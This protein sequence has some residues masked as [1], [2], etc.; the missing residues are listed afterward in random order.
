MKKML[1]MLIILLFPFSIHALDYP[2]LDSKNIEVYDMTDN[3][4]LYEINSKQTISVASLTKIATTITAIENIENLNEKV[5][6]TS[7]ILNTVSKEAS[8]AGLKVGD[9]LTYKDLLYASMLPSGADATNSIAI[10]SSGS[11]EKFVNKMN[12][13]AH[14][15]KLNNTNFVNATGLDEAGHYS[16]ASDITKLLKYALKNP[17]FKEIYTTK[18][19]TLSNGFIVESSLISNYYNPD[20]DTSKILGSKTGYTKDAGYCLS[21]LSI[22]NNHEI[23]IVNL[24]AKKEENKFYNIIDTVNLINFMNDNYKD[25]ILVKK[26]DEIKS[27]KVNLSDTKKYKIVSNK[28][29]IKYLPSD[30]N[31]N[32]LK[33]K[34]SGQKELCFLNKKGEKIGIINYYYDGK[35]I[36]KENVILNKDINISFIKLIKK[37][38]YIILFIFII[39]VCIFNKKILMVKIDKNKKEV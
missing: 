29:I 15:L 27:I 20:Y 22:I 30:Y 25:R 7:D 14:R 5:T 32:D 37:Y 12:N 35:L 10:L 39:F 31:I 4:V 26:G 33:I 8:K 17:I 3:K 38:W 19:Y 11:I 21:S 28:N 9:E 18:K 34:Y 2:K 36:D 1:L 13:L 16:S 24:K 23:I 6:I